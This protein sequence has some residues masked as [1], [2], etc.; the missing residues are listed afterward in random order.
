[1]RSRVSAG[2]TW[3]TQAVRVGPFRGGEVERTEVAR[4]H[5]GPVHVCLSVC[6]SVAFG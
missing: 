5:Y 1:M 3:P 6:L 4:L 2:L